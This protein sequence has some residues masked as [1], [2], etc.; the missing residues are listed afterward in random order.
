MTD[1]HA[2][3]REPRVP[4]SVLRDPGALPAGLQNPV[5]AIGNFD[6]VHRGHA[7][8]AAH[9]KA[10]AARLQKPCA[11]LT[12]EPHPSDFFAARGVVFRLT[13]EKAKA[14]ALQRLGLNGMIVLSFAPSLA[15]LPAEAFVEE[16]LV[17][18]LQIAAAVVGYDFHFGRGRSG[19][20][21]FLRE[22]GAR[23]GFEVD[24]VDKI[25]ADRA[26]SLAAVHSTAARDALQA[27]DVREAARLLGHPW[28]VI[29]EVEHGKKL[30][31]TLGF[32]TANLRLDPS[33]RLRHGIYAV[34]IAIDGVVHGGVA[35][36]GSR[37]TFDDGPPLLEVFVFDF[38][39]DL[40]GKTVEVDFIDWLRP[41]AKFD[42]VEALVEQMGRD[43]EGARALLSARDEPRV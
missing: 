33:C 27:G 25:P 43:V 4:F 12:F 21:S 42:S 10:I 7:A 37:P 19:S 20:P 23:H 35:S 9:A 26:G 1:R 32:P 36:F 5:V 3:E 40:Y 6:G 28:F 24:V 29:G 34:R 17:K 39:A 31:R 41:E 30:G 22:A 11:V 16:I 15:A 38:S 8:V 14:V 2:D 18:R 13:P